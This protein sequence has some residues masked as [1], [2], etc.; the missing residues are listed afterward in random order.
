METRLKEIRFRPVAAAA[1]LGLACLLAL[2]PASAPAQND[3]A[4]ATPPPSS[5]GFLP[6]SE[7]RAG[8]KATAWTVFTGVKPEPMDVEILGVLRGARGPGQ[9]MILAQLHGTKPEYT[10]VVAGMSG[11]PVY[12]GKRLLGSLSYR[13]GQFSKDP[14]AGITP[15]EQMLEV[16]ELPIGTRDSGIGTREQIGQSTAGETMQAMETPLVM[17]GFAPEAVKLWQKQVAGTGLEMV[18]AGG[19]SARAEPGKESL[20]A[21][22]ASVVPG[23]AVSAQLVRGDLEIA[24]T[25][26]VTY[27]D[28]TQLLACGHPILQAGP[29]SLPMTASE[30]VATLASPFNAFKIVNTGATIGAFTEDRE[31]AIRGVFGAQA[32][33]IP[34]HIAIHTESGEKK[35]S[36]EVLDLPSLTTQAVIVSLFQALLQANESTAETSYHLTGTVEL[37]GYPPAPLDVWASTNDQMAAPMMA[38]LLVGERFGRIYSNGTRQGAVK[39]ID[40]HIEAIPHRVQVELEAARLVSSSVVRAGDTVEVEVTLHP[41]KQ[42]ARNLRIAVKLPPRLSQGTLR[43]LVS[44]AGTL[45]RTLDQLRNVVHPISI[46]S[47]LADAHRQH[48]A[49]RVYLSLLVPETQAEMSGQTLTSLPLSVANALEPLRAA[50]DASLNGE[51]VELAAEAPAGGVLSGF[52][53]LNLRIEQ[54]GGLN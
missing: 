11:S 8:M 9:D 27:V 25:C 33:M 48:P 47:V 46:E 42:K 22:A 54:G 40:L 35:L 12:I 10:G 18:A 2:C 36:I 28:A 15:I 23:S 34:L 5:G 45:D 19:G 32:R 26:T 43:L 21:S 20:Q 1:A 3:A 38:A 29:V 14:I 39:G 7:V 24:A 13:V 41:W 44:D 31:S 4:L 6:L 37:G 50:Q 51:S 16:R 53:V 30:V 17:S 52:Q 49:D